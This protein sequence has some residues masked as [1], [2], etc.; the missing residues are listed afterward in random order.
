MFVS[1]DNP[2][3]A[4]YGLGD[5]GSRYAPQPGTTKHHVVR[6]SRLSALA[7]RTVFS[8]RSRH[9]CPGARSL[10]SL[11]SESG[12]P[13]PHTQHVHALSLNP[14]RTT[15]PFRSYRRLASP[16]LFHN[17]RLE[18]IHPH[19]ANPHLPLVSRLYPSVRPSCDRA[20]SPVERCSLAQSMCRFGG[21]SARSSLPLKLSELSSLDAP[22]SASTT[23]MA[24][25]IITYATCVGCP[26]E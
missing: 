5:Y 14:H 24:R 12:L 22:P 6:V 13:T 16:P 2:H 7:R 18:C 19:R 21:T 17:R 15:C 10:L 8:T 9:R 1:S 26:L 20:A 3:L 23:A 11:T 4:T 25:G